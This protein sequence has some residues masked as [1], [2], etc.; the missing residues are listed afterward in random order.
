ME[1]RERGSEGMRITS[2]MGKKDLFCLILFFSPD[3]VTSPT[4]CISEMTG[5][6]L[7]REMGFGYLF[8]G[9]FAIPEYSLSKIRFF[10]KTLFERKRERKS[11][12]P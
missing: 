11:T 12:C 8:W 6:S 7:L 4:C 2:Q 3:L 9:T 10:K 5:D 1:K